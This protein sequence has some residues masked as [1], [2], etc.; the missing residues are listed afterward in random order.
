MVDIDGAAL[1]ARNAEVP[2]RLL[3][4][5]LGPGCGPSMLKGYGCPNMTAV[6]LIRSGVADVF[7]ETTAT[8]T[9]GGEPD[10]THITEALERRMHVITHHRVQEA[11]CA[12]VGQAATI[13][14][15]P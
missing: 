4:D 12:D 11:A 6:E 10:L 5:G 1:S 8:S 13:G 9:L 15:R 2:P 14:P 7:V 3:L